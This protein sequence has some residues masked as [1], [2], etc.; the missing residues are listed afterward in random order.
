MLYEKDF[1]NSACFCHPVGHSAR[2]GR[3]NDYDGS[4]VGGGNH[5]KRI[6]SVSLVICLLLLC[7][8]PTAVAVGNS[9][10][11]TRA[12]RTA[13]EFITLFEGDDDVCIKLIRDISITDLYV[14]AGDLWADETTPD[15]MRQLIFDLNGYTLTVKR[16]AGLRIGINTHLTIKNTKQTG[17]IVFTEFPTDDNIYSGIYSGGVLELDG[18]CISVSVEH[19][20]YSTLRDITDLTQITRIWG[21]VYSSLVYNCG[22]GNLIINSGNITVDGNLIGIKSCGEM[23]INGGIVDLK[24][25]RALG[26]C[27]E[28][29]TITING[30]TINVSGARS[31]GILN[32]RYR[33][34]VGAVYSCE[35]CEACLN[36]GALNDCESPMFSS[37]LEDAPE[38]FNMFGGEIIVEGD[39][40]IG[41]CYK[42]KL[43]IVDGDISAVGAGSYGIVS[44]LENGTIG[45]VSTLKENLPTLIGGR[46]SGSTQA[47]RFVSDTPAAYINHT[48]TKITV[49]EDATELLPGYPDVV[50]GSWYAN[51]VRRL[52]YMGAVEGNAA[53]LFRPFD[54]V[55]LAELVKILSRCSAADGSETDYAFDFDGELTREQVIAVL[56]SCAVQN[57]V[58]VSATTD[59]SGFVDINQVS[60]DALEAMAWAVAAGIINGRS[61][62]E[63]MPQG[64]ATRAEVAVMVMRFVENIK[65]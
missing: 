54:S 40:S 37:R 43:S 27:N 39:N 38:T 6:T 18:A 51:A 44:T 25:N 3:F 30:G 58:D 7:A 52:T 65:R 34:S 42:Y 60:A 32:D 15:E 16:R 29:G 62:S 22:T 48:D 21:T 12:V 50:Y 49:A 46:I 23:I 63:L 4:R 10:L 28:G 61:S 1:D 14:C 5:M 41:V 24:G 9:T 56:Y 17:G 31:I 53:G 55:T 36:G 33:L 45:A 64:L 11:K 26:I 20:E 59:I 8:V 13:E 57:G 2:D 19:D 35:I 47:L